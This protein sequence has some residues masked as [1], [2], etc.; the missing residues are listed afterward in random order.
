MKHVWL[1]PLAL[2]AACGSKPTGTVNFGGMPPLRPQDKDTR[3]ASALCSGC[4]RKCDL[5][6]SKCGKKECGVAL[7]WPE[8]FS[9][10]YC[11]ATG[12]C[13]ACKTWD[14]ADFSCP[15]CNWTGVITFEGKTPPCPQCA[16]KGKCFLCQGSGKCD[17]CGGNKKIAKDKIAEIIKKSTERK[18]EP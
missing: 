10:G 8:T 18:P 11:G 2:L 3:T 7:T 14:R 12:A 1:L 16:C 6:A 5:G 4:G 17:V 9:C 15:N 13:R